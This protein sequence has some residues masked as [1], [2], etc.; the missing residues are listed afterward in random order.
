MEATEMKINYNLTGSGRKALVTVIS[1]LLNTPAIY[2][3][4]PTYAYRIGEYNIDKSGILTGP[5][6]RELIAGLQSLHSLI[7]V[8]E[9]Y[10]AAEE[11]G[12]TEPV[13]HIYEARLIDPSSPDRI[14][15]FKADNDSEAVKQAYSFCIGEIILREVHEL[16]AEYNF[17]RAVDLEAGKPRLT[18]EVPLTGFTPDKFD[19]LC[20]MVTAKESLLKSALGVE[21][22]PIMQTGEGIRFPWFQSEEFIKPE[23]HEAYSTLI[24][25][26]C[27]TAREKKRV[28]AKAGEM[29]INPK[30][31]M[32]CFLLS[33]GMIGIE[34]KTSRR[35]LLSKLE[36]N[37]AWR[38]GAPQPEVGV[39]QAEQAGGTVSAGEIGIEAKIPA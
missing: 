15:I 35:I 29:P 27:E 9:D 4:T 38:D 8:N 39:P 6:N 20:K 12:D 3:R 30:Y 28:T 11:F 16:D 19:N 24:S 23:E 31:A 13:S 14:E 25:L 17:I 22:L 33:L 26:L 5:D 7:P 32:R 18:I 2:L 37:S 21:E 10:D 34:Y 1:Q 36:G